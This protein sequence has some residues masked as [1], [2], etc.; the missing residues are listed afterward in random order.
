MTL[1]DGLDCELKWLHHTLQDPQYS[2]EPVFYWSDNILPISFLEG[3]LGCKSAEALLW[4][5]G[6][7]T[8][9]MFFFQ[10]I[11]IAFTYSW[12]SPVQVPALLSSRGCILQGFFSGVVEDSCQ[13]V[14]DGRVHPGVHT[15][16]RMTSHCQFLKPS[17]TLRS[18]WDCFWASSTMSLG[19]FSLS[20]WIFSR[21]LQTTA[22]L[23]ATCFDKQSFI[24][25]ELCPSIWVLAV[26]SF[27]QQWH[28]WVIMIETVWCTDQMYLL[29]DA[30]ENI[31][32]PLVWSV[33]CYLCI[34]FTASK[35]LLLLSSSLLF[36]SLWIHCSWS[37][38]VICSDFNLN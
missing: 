30:V 33:I 36:S 7:K 13:V 10:K 12:C 25:T 24:R 16:F 9:T 8:L 11:T 28:S 2:L 5:W 38:H 23:L 6:G 3:K 14:W 32:Q 26:A 29:F 4:K 31:C 37:F 35:I 1:L 20:L 22:C 15:K 19:A 18:E 21:R 17:A 34:Y 27:T